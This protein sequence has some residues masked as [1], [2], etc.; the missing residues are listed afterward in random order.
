MSSRREDERCR[1]PLYQVRYQHL[2]PHIAYN[3]ARFD[4]QVSSAAVTL[5]PIPPESAPLV[6]PAS[7]EARS[8]CL[9]GV[10]VLL[11]RRSPGSVQLPAGQREHLLMC[12]FGRP[13]AGVAARSVLRTDSGVRSWRQCPRGHVT[14][15]PAGMPIDWEWNYESQS[16]HLAI[17]PGFLDEIGWQLETPQRSSFCL[18]PAFRILDDSLSVPLLE[19]R[20]EIV[21]SGVGDDLAKSSLLNLI[22]VRLLRR[23]AGD[24]R[25]DRASQ[26]AATGQATAFR[27]RCIE[28]IHDRLDENLSLAE[29]ARECGLSPYHFARLFKQATGFPP[30]EYQLQLRVQRAQVLLLR[31]PRRTIADIACDLGF[32]DESHLRRHFKRIVGIT[33]GQFRA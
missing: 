27:R 23:M 1:G 16:V 13:V 32:A 17:N 31:T 26:D 19:L 5:A 15:V 22:G 12:S 3:R 24:A 25:A 11:R 33:P 30:H 8:A 14:F 6:D 29:I 9:P 20:G 28:L 10:E 18:R 4:H 2:P 7:I 21:A